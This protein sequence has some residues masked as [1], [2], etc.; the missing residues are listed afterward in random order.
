MDNNPALIKKLAVTFELN[1]I[2]ENIAKELGDFGDRAYYMLTHTALKLIRL[3]GINSC[4]IKA[5]MTREETLMA[6]TNTTKLIT[7][8]IKLNRSLKGKVLKAFNGD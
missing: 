4:P 7:N 6:I 5:H 3:V 2:F 8:A 1:P